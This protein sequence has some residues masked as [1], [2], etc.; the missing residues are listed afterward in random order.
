MSLYVIITLRVVSGGVLASVLLAVPAAAPAAASPG[1]GIRGL[2]VSSAQHLRNATINWRALKKAHY[3]FAAIKVSEG[4][5]YVNPYFHSDVAGATAAGLAVLPYVFANPHDSGGAAQADYAVAQIGYRPPGRALPLVIDL[6]KDPY[7][8]TDHVNACYGLSR[9]HMVSWIAAFAA[10]A[11][12]R[13]HRNPLIYTSRRWWHSCTGDSRAFRS[14]P[15][16][17][18]E[19]GTASP[20]PPPAWSRWTIWQYTSNARVQGVTNSGG[21]DLDYAPLSLTSLLRPVSRRHHRQ[22]RA[23]K[24]SRRLLQT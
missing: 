7:K 9:K 3:R 11:R 18:A 10:R 22:H 8:R 21:I 12:A 4:T 5:Y 20:D 6:E 2:D 16:W 19:Y 24:V 23:H 15:L 14:N 13:T 17:I 1:P